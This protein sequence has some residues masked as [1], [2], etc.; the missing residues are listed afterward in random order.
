MPNTFTK[1][2]TVTVG[3]GGAATVDFTS[4]PSIYTDLVVKLSARTTNAYFRDSV[5]VRPNGSSANGSSLFLIGQGASAVSGPLTKIYVEIEGNTGTTASVFGNAEIYITNYTSSN[6]KSF[7]IDAVTENNAAA[8]NALDITASLWSVG[9]PITSLTFA[10]GG[11]FMQYSTV[12]L[13]G[14][15]KD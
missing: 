3:A 5:E 15:K 4:I 11:S 9:S 6:Y 14:V 12:T 2:A 13:Y 10:G 7:S 1:I 8:D